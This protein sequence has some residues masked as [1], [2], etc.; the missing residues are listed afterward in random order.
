MEFIGN[1]RSWIHYICV[2]IYSL[3]CVHG[4]SEGVAQYTQTQCKDMNRCKSSAGKAA[5]VDV[6]NNAAQMTP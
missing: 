1:S 3:L 6:L 5:S 2:P 4:E